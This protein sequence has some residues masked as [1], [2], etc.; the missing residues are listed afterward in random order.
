MSWAVGMNDTVV[1][2]GKNIEKDNHSSGRNYCA[3]LIMDIFSLKIF[4]FISGSAILIKYP[5]AGKS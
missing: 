2:L 4:K 1:R 5:A 3:V